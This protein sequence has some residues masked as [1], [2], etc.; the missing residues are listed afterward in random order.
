MGQPLTDSVERAATQDIPAIIIAAGTWA[1]APGIIA[2]RVIVAAVPVD[3]LP[4]CMEDMEGVT[5]AAGLVA[6]TQVAVAAVAIPE[7]EAAV[8]IHADCAA[9]LLPH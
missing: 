9:I 8:A 2:A 1:A 7:V 3:M 6:D 5:A 4:A